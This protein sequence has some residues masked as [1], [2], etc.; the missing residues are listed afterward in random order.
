MLLPTPPFSGMLHARRYNAGSVVQ[1]AADGT[2]LASFS[3]QAASFRPMGIAVVQSAG[4]EPAVV[5]VADYI[6]NEVAL[7]ESTL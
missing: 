5:A 4:V 1:L 6:N 7:F 2:V 3:G